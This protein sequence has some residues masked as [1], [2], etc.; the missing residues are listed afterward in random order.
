MNR[1]P[2]DEG[3]AMRKLWFAEPFGAVEALGVLEYAGLAGEG[4]VAKYIRRSAPSSSLYTE[5]RLDCVGVL[6]RED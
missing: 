1:A 2:L 5:A 6:R 3:F 4:D